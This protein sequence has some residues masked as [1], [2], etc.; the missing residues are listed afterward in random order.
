MIGRYGSALSILLL[1]T[2]P[3]C[4][5]ETI[6]PQQQRE[7]DT[8]L[9]AYQAGNDRETLRLADDLLRQTPGGEAA[10]QAYYLRGMAEYRLK[11][12]DLARQD[13]ERVYR[14]TR[15]HDLRLKAIDALGEL[16]YRRGELAAAVTLLQ[17]VVAQTFAGDKPADHAHY[18]LG[19]IFQQQG[20]WQDADVHLE[21]VAC[22]FKDSDLA[23][24]ARQRTRA[25]KWTI[26]IGS[27]TSRA[28]ADQ[29]AQ[30]L[31]SNG[32]ETYIE[33]VMRNDKVVFI[34]Q[35]GRWGRFELAETELPSV[36]KVKPDAFLQ[37]T[38]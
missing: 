25:R 5:R 30:R 10:M 3:G 31:R 34:L 20:R 33:P 6:S 24:K 1:L 4:A 12:D 36:R 28:N 19:C 38:R 37:V 13:L 16:A 18:R 7:L 14:G 8:A 22:D 27:Y 15:N 26:Q 29:E 21:R 35:V 17:E 9:S 2:S 11:E 23:R 32:F